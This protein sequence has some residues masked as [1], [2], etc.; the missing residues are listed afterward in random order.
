MPIASLFTV[1]SVLDPFTVDYTVYTV[2]NILVPS[3]LYAYTV[4]NVY[5]C[6][7]TVYTVYHIVIYSGAYTS[8]KF[9][10][11][12][13]Y[14]EERLECVDLLYTLGRINMKECVLWT[15]ISIL[16]AAVALLVL[17]SLGLV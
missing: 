17:Y 3:P 15:A 4:Y 14:T 6:V 2:Y 12:L 5:V 9:I 10:Q 7:Y 8:I 16:A 11:G 13:L 1:L